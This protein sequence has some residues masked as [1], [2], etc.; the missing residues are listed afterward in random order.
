M[1]VSLL[2][3]ISNSLPAQ[4]FT[5]KLGT[6]NGLVKLG[7]GLGAT[8]LAIAL[9]VLINKVGIAWTFRILGFITLATGLPAAMLLK[10]GVVASQHRFLELSM[11]RNPAYSAVF[12]A[13]ALGTFTL[14]APPYFL[15]FIA[16]SAGLS[17]ATGAGLV[18]G[19]N[20][21]TAVGRVLSGPMCDK[22]G[23]ANT[24]LATM[25]LSAS[26]MLAMW[27]FSNSFGVL[28]AFTMLNGIANGS[29]FVAMPTVVA[30]MFSPEQAAVA[31]GQ[32]ITGWTAGY[33]MGAPIAGYLLQA[34]NAEQSQSID[35]YRAAM[36][37]AGGMA[38]ASSGFVLAARLSLDRKL[39]KRV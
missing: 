20:A 26:T 23:P 34:T 12:I 28:V 35:P 3:S 13:A 10:E 39:L 11:F 30:K 14:F 16:K 4:Y 9:E 1:G 6:V 38:L 24:F 19:F 18:A 7:G 29:F 15:P 33:L 32:A 25:L 17:S 36:F 21:C 5:T 2:Y 22:I 31:M 8:I 37:Y 27:P